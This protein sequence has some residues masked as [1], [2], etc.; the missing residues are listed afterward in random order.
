MSG[1]LHVYSD[2]ATLA[3]GLAELFV[4]VG[5]AAQAERGAFSVALAGGTTP[6]AAYALVTDPELRFSIS[7]DNVLVSFGDERCVAPTDD[8]SNYKMANDTFLSKVKIPRRNIH[9]IEAEI[10]PNEAARKYARVLRDDVGNPPHLDLVML[11]MGPDGHTASLFPGMPP[12]TDQEKLVRAVRAEAMA[13]MYRITITPYVINNAR[14]VV[15]ATEGAAKAE[16]LAAVREGPH[17]P[18]KYPAQIVNPVD[19]RLLWLVDEAAAS[20]LKQR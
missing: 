15:F 8:Q 9:R 4:S 2:P 20:R 14:T 1:E 17:D 10:Y 3:A 12:E 16:T 7:W 5:H 18:T 19:G 11:G 6:R 13:T